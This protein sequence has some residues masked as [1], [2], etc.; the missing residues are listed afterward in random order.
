M[1][2][3]AAV[4][5]LL[6][7]IVPPAFAQ[8]DTLPLPKRDW[9][10]NYQAGIDEVGG[11]KPK[12]KDCCEFLCDIFIVNNTG[13]KLKG[14]IR[15]TMHGYPGYVVDIPGVCHPDGIVSAHP[16][17]H[18][19]HLWFDEITISV[20]DGEQSASIKVPFYHCCCKRRYVAEY[21]RGVLKLIEK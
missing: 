13:T 12:P 11:G 19:W 6:C 20:W 7:S 9:K 5:F 18:P 3:F 14:W 1:K 8:G 4:T 10:T 15:A 21:I 17:K 2:R 16:C